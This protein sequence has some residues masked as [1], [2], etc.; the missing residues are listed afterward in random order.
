MERKGIS[1][2][3]TTVLII[4]LAIAAVVLIW[5]FISNSIK[6]GGEQ[7]QEFLVGGITGNYPDSDTASVGPVILSNDWREYTIDLRGKDLSYLSGGFAW[8]SS[9]NVNGKACI[10]YLDDIRFE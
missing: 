10:F 2:I 7:I 9:E 6:K 8:T 4:L 1:D 3:V 5:G